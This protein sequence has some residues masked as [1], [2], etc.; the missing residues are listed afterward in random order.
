MTVRRRAHVVLAVALSGCFWG[1][2]PDDSPEPLQP[3]PPLRAVWAL[4]GG[5]SGIAVPAGAEIAYA[6]RLGEL[7]TIGR[8]RRSGTGGFVTPGLTA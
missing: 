3:G 4:D 8:P 1:N 6:S 2:I 5:W 7:V